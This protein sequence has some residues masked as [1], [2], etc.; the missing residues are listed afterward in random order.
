MI[1]FHPQRLVRPF[2]DYLKSE[3]ISE[4]NELLTQRDSIG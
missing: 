4:R 1:V 3:V 2:Y